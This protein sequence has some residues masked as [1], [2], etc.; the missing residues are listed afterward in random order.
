MP[1]R[2]EYNRFISYVNQLAFKK[3]NRRFEMLLEGLS[4]PLCVLCGGK[5]QTGR[6]LC[7]DCEQDLPVIDMACMQCGIPL[8]VE[9]VCG[10]CLRRPPAFSFTMAVFHYLPPLDSLVK[11]LKYKGELHLARLLGGLIAERLEAADIDMPDIIVPVPLHYRR[12][13]ERGYNQALELARPIAERMRLPIDCFHVTRIRETDPQSALSASQRTR[14]VKN[15]FAVAHEFKSK[16]VAIVDDVMTTGH[17][18]NELALTLRRNGA[19]NISVWVCARA[20]FGG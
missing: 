12:L 5:G 19:T 6:E 1:K 11:K 7:L 20:V 8:P 13:Q 3:V 18:V 14:N 10:Q 9:G 17:T 2:T 16:S 15:A 4:P